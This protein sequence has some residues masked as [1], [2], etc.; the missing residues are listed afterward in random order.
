VR[1]GYLSFQLGFACNAQ[2]PFC[3]L[4][5]HPPHQPD[6]DER[7]HRQALLKRFHRQKQRLEGVA[8]TGGEPLLYL[9]ELEACTREMLAAR[10][11]LYLWV[12]SNGLLATE[13][14][15]RL[16]A[17]L[18]IREI[19]FNLAATDYGDAGLASVARAKGII[20]HVV[21]EVACY[22]PQRQALLSC[23]PELE[24]IG[25]DQLNLQELW[26]T[27]AN[28]QR[29]TGE[30]YKVGLLFGQKHFLCGSRRLT[31]EVMAHCLD[32]GYGFTVNDCTA[33][34]FGRGGAG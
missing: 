27:P 5:T 24:R 10:P 1:Q 14:N 29:V 23:L 11:E 20:E 12:Y 28:L 8:L 22:P 25:I 33:G 17:D 31:Y 21:V 16:L 6:D 7:Y 13:E 15:L 9:P 34:T 30:G 19:R 18:G 3:F 26:L 4:E 32:A 2:C